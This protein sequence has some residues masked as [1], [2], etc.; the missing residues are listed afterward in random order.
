MILIVT[1]HMKN[2]YHS[3]FKSEANENKMNRRASSPSLTETMARAALQRRKIFLWGA[4]TDESARRVINQLLYLKNIA[5]DQRADRRPA[6][7]I[8][9]QVEKAGEYGLV[10]QINENMAVLRGLSGENF[11]AS[12]TNAHKCNKGL[13][14]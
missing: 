10:D 8:K 3:E 7:N 2:L 6:I 5:P 11:P 9:I 1:A 13:S 14:D 12:R 4:V